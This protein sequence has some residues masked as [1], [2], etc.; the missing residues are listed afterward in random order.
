MKLVFRRVVRPV[1]IVAVVLALL[2][3]FVFPTQTWNDQRG[4]LA[5]TNARIA[6]LKSQN[7]VLETR[8]AAL[9]QADEIERLARQDFSLVYPGESPFA[10]LPPPPQP[11]NLPNAWPFTVLS[12][13]L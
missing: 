2:G 8:V 12:E 1:L 6:E 5:K 7:E 9:D 4:A 11:V 10:V 13:S 3:Y